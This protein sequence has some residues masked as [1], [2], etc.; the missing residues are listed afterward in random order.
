MSSF[1]W[2]E[3]ESRVRV[4]NPL[5]LHARP[6]VQLVQLAA[7]FDAETELRVREGAWTDARSLSS[8]MKLKVASGTELFVRSRGAQ[9]A[10]ALE[11]LVAFIEQSFEQ[12]PV[13]P[14]LPSTF[15]HVTEPDTITAF[16][17]SEGVAKGRPF[18]L[19]QTKETG[20]LAKPQNDQPK[21]FSRVL[22]QVV[23]DLERIKGKS[24]EVGADII[25]FQLEL[26][27][28]D[29]FVTPIRR[30]V[31]RGASAAVAWS[32]AFTKE[33]DTYTTSGDSI[34]KSRAADLRDLSQRFLANID[35][36]NSKASKQLPNLNADTILL[37]T[38]LFPS[39]F[40]ELDFGRVKGIVSSQ[41]DS[42]SHVA[43]LARA[44]GIPFATELDENELNRLSHAEA[45]LMVCEGQRCE[46]TSRLA[47]ADKV[48]QAQKPKTV[49][50]S[51]LAEDAVT[52]AGKRITLYLNVDDPKRLSQTKPEHCDGIGLVRTEFLLT[53][54]SMLLSEE[55]QFRVYRDIIT[56][57]AGKPVTIRTLDAGGDKPVDELVKP[58]PNPMLGLRGLRLSLERQD[59]FGYQ[60][61]ALLRAAA[62]GPLKVMFPVVSLVSEY[63]AA[64]E[65]F[66]S[67]LA[68]LEA[69]GTAAKMPE[70]GIMVETPAAALRAGD[71]DTAFYSIGTNDL[72]QYTFAADR[73]RPEFHHLHQV[74]H[75]A[76]LDLIKHVVTAGRAKR[77]EVSVCGEVA[78]QPSN[79]RPLLATGI[80]TLSVS[81]AALDAVK[82]EIAWL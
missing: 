73:G 49:L 44:Y 17:V 37:T 50:S 54:K 19:E 60:V 65:V 55:A 80:A 23:S 32:E 69:K 79:L 12:E 78:S 31:E 29:A 22:T 70:L 27:Q 67:A 68:A 75:P 5:G 63:E 47:S 11:A 28:D 72:A 53:N 66:R 34:L 64:R 38:E 21:L 18:R 41:S 42:N 61:R 62:V 1:T 33:A 45:L 58:E 71:Y 2:Q 7:E 59:V 76:V 24:D 16:C 4:S 10:A 35:S 56:W 30:R 9:A 39:Q 77:V 8:V 74:T 36:E 40:L 52:S 26:L 51:R 46:F 14:A 25:D 57:A 82:R 15:E 13:L 6:A 3:T 43:L 48:Q 81:A 20:D